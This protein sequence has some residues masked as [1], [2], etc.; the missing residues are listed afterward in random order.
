[1]MMMMNDRKTVKKYP[2]SAVNLSFG[3]KFVLSITITIT[4]DLA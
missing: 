2:K 1:M 4:I 3:T